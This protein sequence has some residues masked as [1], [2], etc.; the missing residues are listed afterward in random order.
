MLFSSSLRYEVI[1]VD[2]LIG[3]GKLLNVNTLLVYTASG[4]ISYEIEIFGISLSASSNAALFSSSSSLQKQN[5]IHH[6]LV[7]ALD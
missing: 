7:F 5:I 3:F 6:L 1:I 4:S 2:E